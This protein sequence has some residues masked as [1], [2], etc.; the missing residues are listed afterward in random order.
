VPPPIAE[1]AEASHSNRLII[2][3][4]AWAYQLFLLWRFRRLNSYSIP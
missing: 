4:T 3:I 2:P 1:Q